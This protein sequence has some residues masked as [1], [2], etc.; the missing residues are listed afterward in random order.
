MSDD[1]NAEV[2]RSAQRIVELVR[3][4]A[5]EDDVDLLAAVYDYDQAYR[6]SR[7]KTALE[8]ISEEDPFEGEAVPDTPSASEPRTP[9]ATIPE[10]ETAELRYALERWEAVLVRRDAKLQ[11]LRA[12][13]TD[14]EL[15]PDAALALAYKHVFRAQSVT[16]NLR[17]LLTLAKSPYETSIIGGTTVLSATIRREVVNEGAEGPGAPSFYDDVMG[18]GDDD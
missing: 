17:A 1:R 13:H 4:R 2:L 6:L 8:R 15:P 16:R 14:P 12:L 10:A 5:E 3:T 11:S 7:A 18:L 9:D